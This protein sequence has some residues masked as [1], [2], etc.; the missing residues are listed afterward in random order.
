MNKPYLSKKTAAALLTALLAAGCST[1]GIDSKVDGQNP[2]VR[3]GTIQ[4]K[5]GN[6][7]I[8]ANGGNIGLRFEYRDNNK[9][10]YPK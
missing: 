4:T 9:K 2:R 6:V 3:I 8:Y 10:N 1:V 7:R 5:D